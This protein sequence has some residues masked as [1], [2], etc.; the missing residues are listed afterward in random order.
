M[1]D[2]TADPLHY[3]PDVETIQDDEAEAQNELVE[4]IL[5]ISR[6]TYHDEDEA[7]RAVHAKSHGIVKGKMTVF[8]DLPLQFRQG[9]FAHPGE[10]Q[11]IM[12]FSTAP[13][14]LLPDNVSTPRGLAVRLLGVEGPRLSGAEESTTQDFVLATGKA[15][16]VKDAKHF[17]A[18]LKALASTTDKGEGL[19]VVL[20]SLLRAAE[21]ALETVGGE[22][23]TLKTLGGY[24]ETHILGECFFSQVP[25]RFGDYI[26]KIGIF[27]VSRELVELIGAPLDLGSGFDAL[28]QA[29]RGF[30]QESGGTW[31]LRVQL[32]T[33]LE[34]MPVED[35]AAVWDEDKSPYVAVARLEVPPQESWSDDLREEVDKGMA[36]SPWQGLAAHR[37]LGSINR[38]RRE[39]YPS[40]A[41]FRLE[42]NGCPVAE[43]HP[44][45]GRTA[46]R[47]ATVSPL[48]GRNM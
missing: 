28:R 43:P 37:P 25:F 18:N 27:P 35:A 8:A 14:D 39:A 15:F 47:A 4:Q 19:K 21:G 38:A 23:A 26:A 13:G 36:F 17:A 9:L 40:S 30:F 3:S 48:P 16:S 7:L 6:Q 42:R 32:C 33:N 5:K 31:E 46:N 45:S 11:A 24:P 20:S 29:V 41:D 22:S 10:Y 12:R 1:T 2:A 44:V 34:D